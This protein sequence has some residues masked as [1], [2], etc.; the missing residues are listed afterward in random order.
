MKR[1]V[2]YRL[3]AEILDHICEPDQVGLVY[4]KG[5]VVLRLLVI[6]AELWIRKFG[7]VN[8]MH[9][10]IKMNKSALVAENNIR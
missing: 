8:K 4:V 2:A 7:D 6:V 9:T 3:A 5:D 10:A 1:G